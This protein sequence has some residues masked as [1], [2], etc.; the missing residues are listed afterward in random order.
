MTPTTFTRK[1]HIH[2][3]RNTRRELRR[4]ASP[5]R[6]KFR[7]PRIS[8]L[9][10]LAI[11]YDDMINRGQIEDYATVARFGQLSRA[12]ISQI[13]N[14]VRLAPDIQEEILFMPRTTKGRDWL[15]TNNLGPISYEFDWAR[16]RVRWEKLKAALPPHVFNGDGQTEGTQPTQG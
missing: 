4:G 11:H 13:I 1:L 7:T 9:M 6:P 14:L 8:K 12:R 10:A 15:N 2:I 5:K 3:G 16:Q